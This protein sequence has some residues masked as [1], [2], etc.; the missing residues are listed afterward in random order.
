M[1]IRV[2]SVPR[3]PPSSKMCQV[4]LATKIC[5]LLKIKKVCFSWDSNP[6]PLELNLVLNEKWIM[7]HV[8]NL[9]KA[10]LLVCSFPLALS[11]EII[12][13]YFCWCFKLKITNQNSR[14]NT[15]QSQTGTN[16]ISRNFFVYSILAWARSVKNFP[17]LKK[18]LLP[19]Q[20]RFSHVSGPLLG[21]ES[22]RTKKKTKG[23]LPDLIVTCENW[24]FR[25]EM[26]FLIKNYSKF[27]QKRDS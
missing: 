20:F 22:F 24:R 21:L 8:T 15:D 5:W 18:I 27:D 10:A 6:Q 4:Q 12:W 13:L 19:I 16:L 17:S 9:I 2:N 1:D 7:G 23:V 25:T 11:F 26:S 14:F 3:A